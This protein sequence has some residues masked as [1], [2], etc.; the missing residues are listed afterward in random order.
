MKEE[1]NK[2]KISIIFAI[3]REEIS[4]FK[5]IDHILPFL[6]ILSKNEIL[7]FNATGIIFE[8]KSN[9]IQNL[10]P[11]IEFL[12]D[13]RNIDLKFLYKDDFLVK[14]KKLIKLNINYKLFR[15]YNNLIDKLYNK[16]LKI[17][18]KK[19]DLEKKLGE[20]FLKSEFPLIITLH[21]NYAAQQ[22]FSNIKKINSKT[23]WI[24]LPH[25]TVLTENKMVL[26]SDLNKDE[27]VNKDEIYKKIDFFC[28]TSKRDLKNA[29]S[30]GMDDHKG[31]V[32]GSPRYCDE[33]LKTKKKI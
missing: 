28:C 13:L 15:T 12:S 31:L 24:V 33:W 1:K 8:N 20:N 29:I 16:L 21:S 18:Q 30:E 11:R 17:R 7:E 22:I 3:L 2:K 14:L 32:I 6:Y 19:I 9:Y 5:D 26:E 4:G 10:D 27:K 23:K 25:G